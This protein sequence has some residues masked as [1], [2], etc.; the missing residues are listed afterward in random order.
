MLKVLFAS[1]EF[2]PIAATGG[3]GEVCASLP[4][5][6][7]AFG[8]ECRVIIPGYRNVRDT[9]RLTR[10]PGPLRVPGWS[11]PIEVLRG[12]LD[13]GIPVYVVDIPELF[14]RPGGLYTAAGGGEWPDNAFRFGVFSRAVA[15]LASGAAPAEWLPD[16]VH[17]HDWQTGLIPALLHALPLRPA[18]IFTIHN[19][20]YQGLCDRA[21]FLRLELPPAL[22]HPDALE[23]Y[24]QC[25]LIKGGIR[26]ADAV[27]TVSPT[28]AR[29]IQTLEF[30]NGLDGLLRAR[31]PVL[32][33]ILNG[34]DYR[35]WNPA[36]DRFLTQR[37]DAERLDQKS[38]NKQ[39]LQREFGLAVEPDAL[40]LGSVTRLTDQKGIDLAIDAFTQLA[41]E[42]P[43]QLAVLGTGEPELEAALRELMRAQPT[44][45]AVRFGYDEALAH[46]VIA[47][48]DALLMPSRFEPCGLTQLCS[49]RYGT[50]PIARRTGGLADSVD[51]AHNGGPP[52]GT[53]GF[54]FN[55]VS[56]TDLAGAIR[57]A[58]R[59]YRDPASWRALQGAG[60]ARDFSW[61]ASAA[62]YR[63]TYRRLLSR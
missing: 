40:L 12:D 49:Q 19:L 34:I 51:D 4:V 3:L 41:L 38:A 52:A 58:Y 55:E 50:P 42:L 29:E 32:S 20:A 8:C 60:M 36:T 11:D 63:D 5:A 39:Q 15:A 7:R 46:R 9:L 30:G 31:A 14:N 1:S 25:A 22:W 48:L 10:L 47:G 27:T 61:S 6:L 59:W 43:I 33:G 18:T 24:G 21:T 28:Y 35:Q 54:L 16:L 56:T 17:C 45:V 2:H 37:Y 62:L 44:R 23:F 26:F 57:R 13:S 53:T